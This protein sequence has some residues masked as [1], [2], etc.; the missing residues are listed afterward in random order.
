MRSKFKQFTL[1]LSRLLIVLAVTGAGI[2]L[3]GASAAQAAPVIRTARMA[4]ATSL[5]AAAPD[6]TSVT[7]NLSVVG[8]CGKWKGTLEGYVAGVKVPETY[9][10]VS[11]TLSAGCSGTSTG[12]L[13]YSCS[14]GG[15]YQPREPWTTKSST[16]TD[17]TT[18]GCSEGSSAYVELY[19]KG[20]KGAG[21]EDSPEVSV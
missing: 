14:G 12:R 21:A 3:L 1:T 19:W 4:S 9:I 18:A 13:Y 7:L 16:G 11:G 10:E 20:P 6:A 5:H 8:G 2:G 17:F 15:W